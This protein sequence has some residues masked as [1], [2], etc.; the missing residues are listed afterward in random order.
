[1]KTASAKDVKAHFSAFLK[2]S[3]K[4]PIIVTRNGKPAAVLVGVKDDDEVER[5]MMANSPRLQAILNAARK[6]F[7]AG[8]G[9]PEE[10]FWKSVKADTKKRRVSKKIA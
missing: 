4:G 9:I 6:R 3:A 5:L 2:A 1:M 10:T 7:Q 8:E